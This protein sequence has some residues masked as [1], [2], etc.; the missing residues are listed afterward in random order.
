MKSELVS[1]HQIRRPDLA[2]LQPR[3]LV[4]V[5]TPSHPLIVGTTELR[6]ILRCRVKHHWRH[7]CNLE[8]TGGS[9]N[10]QMGGLIH[11]IVEAWYSL[12]PGVRTN[13][14]MKKLARRMVGEARLSALDQEHYDLIEAMCV[15]FAYWVLDPNTE[16][17]DA[18]IGLVRCQA[19]R[20]F[21]YPLTDDGSIRV[22][23]H[24]DLFFESA[25]KRR[26][27]AG[28]ETKSRSSFRDE[29]LDQTL[30]LSV[31]LWAMR[32]IAKHELKK[33]FKRYVMYFQRLRKQMPTP[34]V[35]APLFA[36]D[37]I[38]RDDEQI[39]A[40]RQDTINVLLEVHG[41]AVYANPQ[42]DCNWSCDFQTPC[43]MRG[44]PDD[45][46]HILTTQYQLREKRIWVEK[47]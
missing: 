47:R 1:I 6:D 45:V 30:Q 20:Q 34:R 42:E 2:G 9:E 31:Y 25:M 7:Q 14:A 22:R 3:R 38:E 10:L 4:K 40:W 37:A 17:N 19:E 24:I 41:G 43:L 35:T 13:K 32:M 8:P 33:K 12:A 26:T 5:P 46:K 29:N 36:R 27:L 15:G 28:C 23:S 18:E 21:D 44:N 39:E 11:L 16:D